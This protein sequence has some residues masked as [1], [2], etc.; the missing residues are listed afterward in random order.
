M[1]NGERVNEVRKS[2]GLTLEK[3]GEKLGVTKT[4]IS[5]IEKGVNNLTDQMA[6]S[7]CREYNVNYDYLM[8]GE[9][10]M[11]DDL[12][13][14]IVDEL[15]AQYDLNDFDKA[16]VEMYVSLPAGSRERIKEYMKQLVKKVGWDKTE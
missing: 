14:T 16:L 15:C 12:P 1:T 7:I 6:I 3:F 10:E 9:G 5:R 4:T 11:F 2:L 8:Y 13:Q